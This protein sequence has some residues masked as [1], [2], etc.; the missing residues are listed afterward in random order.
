MSY[1]NV[2]SDESFT[3]FESRHI[4]D[5]CDN[6]AW[7]EDAGPSMRRVSRYGCY[8]KDEFDNLLG[9][10]MSIYDSWLEAKNTNPTKAS[11]LWTAYSRF[12]F[13]HRNVRL[14]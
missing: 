5:Y 8:S 3:S 9:Q 2:Y 11:E 6:I 7:W 10:R 14:S 1:Y 12:W 13:E 4:A